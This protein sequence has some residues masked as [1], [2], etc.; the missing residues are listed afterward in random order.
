MKIGIVGTGAI[1]GYF[2][3]KLASSGFE[4]VFLSRGRTLEILKTHGLTLETKEKT[5]IIREAIFT[6]NPSE[7]KTCKYILFSVKSYDTQSTINKIK[8]YIGDNAIVIT[9]QNGIN[10]DLILSKVLGK[11]RVIPALTKGG[12]SSPNLGHFKNLGFAILEFGEYDGKISPRLTEFA[13]ICNKAG[14][15][16]IV[17]KQIQTERWKKYILNCTFNIISAITRLRTDQMLNNSKIYYL[18]IQTMKEIISVA[19]KEGI[20][21]NESNT[22]KEAIATVK[23]LGSFK[24][25]T[26]QDIEN[27]KPIELEAFTGYV[28]KLA[29]K[30]KV[31]VP[32]NKIF[33]SLLSGI[34]DLKNE[35]KK[36]RRFYYDGTLKNSFSI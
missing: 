12:Y 36:S 19:S 20:I 28:L 10:N 14:I 27:G 11:K 34:I 9:Q 21:L 1:G 8:N 22:I 25:S 33:Y 18:S 24:T 3:G 35:H 5:S 32:I 17:S 6:D 7:L 15:E 2:G 26:L 4:V 23:K 16:T 30:H 29:H 13:N 31:K